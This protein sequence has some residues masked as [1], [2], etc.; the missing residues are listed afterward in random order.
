[1][2]YKQDFIKFMINA[3]A[4]TFGDFITK[5]GRATPYF[6]NTGKYNHGQDI[7]QLGKYYASCIRDNIKL[8]EN[9]VLFGP[10]YKGIPLVVATSIALAD[11][12][13]NVKYCFNRKEAKDH[14]EGGEVVGHKLSPGDNVIIIEDVITAGTAV[15][16]VMPLL[17]SA[18]AMVTAL[19]ISV[20]RMERGTGGRTAIQEIK[21]EF[22]INTYPIVNVKEIL[23][24]IDNAELVAQM[25]AYMQK[26]CN[27]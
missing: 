23:G 12:G 17:Q 1:M 8:T 24:S 25:Q 10:A 4:L 16:E 15:R 22:G 6:V 3:G 26:Y 11:Q 19:V 18:G 5:S 14:G 21:E 20:D 13:I 7:A 27:L 2:T 9:T